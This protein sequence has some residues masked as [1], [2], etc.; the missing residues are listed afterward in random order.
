[1]NDQEPQVP[2]AV[3][4]ANIIEAVEAPVVP[5]PPQE[6][7]AAQPVQEVNNRAEA[8]EVNIRTCFLK[9]EPSV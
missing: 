8:L 6:N 1:M 4:V 5:E 2:P 9:L 3:A 7:R